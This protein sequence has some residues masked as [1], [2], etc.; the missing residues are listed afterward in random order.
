MA[1][2]LLVAVAAQAQLVTYPQGL[3]AGMAHND[4]YTVRVRTL[5]G[6]WQDLFEYNVQVD[7]D[8]VQDATMVQFDMGCPVEVMVKKNNGTVRD[9]AIRPTR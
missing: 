4:D 5:D 8:N 6:E 9:V 7:M 1:V 3:N 2:I